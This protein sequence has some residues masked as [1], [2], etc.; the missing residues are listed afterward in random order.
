MTRRL[1]ASFSSVLKW[2]LLVRERSSPV[3]SASQRNTVSIWKGERRRRALSLTPS[4]SSLVLVL[5]NYNIHHQANNP[6]YSLFHYCKEAQFPLVCRVSNL[7]L[8]SLPFILF[9]S[10]RLRLLLVDAFQQFHSFIQE[11]CSIGDGKSAFYIT[12]SRIFNDTVRTFLQGLKNGM[13]HF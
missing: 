2:I 5:R 11:T 9:T 10:K 1:P 7:V 13:V 4:F 6:L 8:V 3:L 12:I